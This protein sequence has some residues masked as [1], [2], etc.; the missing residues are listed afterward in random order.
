MARCSIL[1]CTALLVYLSITMQGCGGGD[2]CADTPVGR[3]CFQSGREDAK[4]ILGGTQQR[5]ADQVRRD[6]ESQQSS[7]ER[8]ERNQVESMEHLQHQLAQADQNTK[9]QCMNTMKSM[10]AESKRSMQSAFERGQRAGY[11]L[12][13]AKA[14][15][16]YNDA[17]WLAL[18][19]SGLGLVAVTGILAY[20]IINHCAGDAICRRDT[21]TCCLFCCCPFRR[22]EKGMLGERLLMV[23]G[24]PGMLSNH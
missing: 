23:Q 14:R 24:N 10:S 13:Y 16:L 8:L 18:C 3:Q 22:S 17:P 6:R 15:V 11:N 20:V 19:V 21:L 4:D 9:V 2:A 5:F 7:M 12:G 1:L